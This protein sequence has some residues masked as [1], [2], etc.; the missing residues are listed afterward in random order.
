MKRVIYTPDISEVIPDGAMQYTLNVSGFV[1][2]AIVP[3]EF[4]TAGTIHYDSLNSV[5]LPEPFIHHFAG[6]EV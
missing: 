6:W 4:V 2:D 5:E 3:D 1:V